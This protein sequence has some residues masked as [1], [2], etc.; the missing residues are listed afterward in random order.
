[1]IPSC[2]KISLDMGEIWDKIYAYRFVPLTVYL[3]GSDHGKFWT[4]NAVVSRQIT[5]TYGRFQYYVGYS[6]LIT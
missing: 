6:K 2:D 3:N 5:I 1:M 4:R